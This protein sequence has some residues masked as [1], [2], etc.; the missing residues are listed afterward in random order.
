[1]SNQDNR[2]YLSEVID[3]DTHIKPYQFIKIFAGVGSGKNTF[4]DN[5]AKGNV[6]HHSD[7]SLVKKK[8]ILLITSRRA[9]VNEQLNSDVV[10]Y[11]PEIGAFDSP[12]ADWFADLD[13]RYEDYYE[14]PTM[15]LPD[16]DGWGR[17]RVYRR[18][19]VN[20]NAKIE[21]NLRKYY[22]PLDA[23]THPWERFDMIVV[24]EVHA[25]LADASYQSAPFYVRRLIEETLQRSTKCKVIVM[26]GSPQILDNQP[27][28]SDAHCIDMMDVCK[29]I[30]PARI[31]F[32]SKE[33]AREMQ[34]GMLLRQEPF[35]AFFNHIGDMLALVDDLPPNSMIPSPFRSPKKRSVPN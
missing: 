30:R 13:P 8:Y 35:V 22:T 2:P 7:G 25:L 31:E 1:M 18:T 23:R 21:H 32:I 16:L 29:N 20:T 15:K 14:S 19:C 26:T 6:F 5:L 17:A 24:D 9:K 34:T 3:Y 33:Q 10:V 4:V 11:D 12:Y 27:L 28:F